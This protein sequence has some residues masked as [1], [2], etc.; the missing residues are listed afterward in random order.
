MVY[1]NSWVYYSA[2]HIFF[3]AFMILL[4]T[5]SDKVK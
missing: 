1:F 5:T 4:V 2:D 3:L